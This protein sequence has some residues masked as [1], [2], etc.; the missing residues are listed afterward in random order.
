MKE[1]IILVDL[2]GTLCDCEWRRKEFLCDEKKNF[3]AFNKAAIRDMPN[4]WCLELIK[5]MGA[6]LVFPLYVSGRSD[7]CR[8]ITMEWLNRWL[9]GF[10]NHGLLM[11][12]AGDYRP[13]VEVKKEFLTQVILPLGHTILF[14]VDDRASVVQM[15]RDN[16]ITC[17]Q[18]A[19][20]DF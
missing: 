2:D 19:K 7:D 4:H 15:W 11:R 18:C 14:A 9:P 20:G 1:E 13:D 10:K 5:A 3:D 16:N 12:K 8:D 6:R 17:L